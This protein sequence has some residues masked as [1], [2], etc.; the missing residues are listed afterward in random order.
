M[1]EP[2]DHRSFLQQVILASIDAGNR[3]LVDD[4]EDIWERI[5]DKVRRA[6]ETEQTAK[7]GAHAAKREA[8]TKEPGVHPVVRMSINGMPAHIDR[9]TPVLALPHGAAEWIVVPAEAV[10][11]PERYSHWKEY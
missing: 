3:I 7:A 8:I 11:S 9:N 5:E 6:E 10:L 4:A 2:L 1:P